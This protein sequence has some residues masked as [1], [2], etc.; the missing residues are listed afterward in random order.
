MLEPLTQGVLLG[1]EPPGF[2]VLYVLGHGVLDDLIEVRVELHVFELGTLLHPQHVV[3][4]EN[5]AISVG[6]RR[7]SYRFF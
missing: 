4:D 7:M 6:T 3:Y 2:D 1:G 5:L